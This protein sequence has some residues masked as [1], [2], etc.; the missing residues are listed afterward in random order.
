MEKATA[1]NSW[2]WKVREGVGVRW[3]LRLLC[4]GNAQRVLR[5][6]KLETGQNPGLGRPCPH[7]SFCLRRLFFLPSPQSSLG[8]FRSQSEPSPPASP[9]LPTQTTLIP[10]GRTK[11]IWACTHLLQILTLPTC[12]CYLGYDAIGVSNQILHCL[13]DDINDK[14]RLLFLAPEIKVAT[15]Q[16]LG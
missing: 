15:G 7:N 1:N 6:L 10:S 9:Y 3:C 4:V 8:P 5:G 14:G 12:R 16:L 11:L 2:Q 13:S